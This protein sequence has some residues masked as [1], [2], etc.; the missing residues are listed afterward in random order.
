MVELVEGRMHAIQLQIHATQVEAWDQIRQ[1]VH[2]A[3]AGEGCRQ[4]A[5][6]LAHLALVD[7][8]WGH[9]AQH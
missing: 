5:Q 7:G 1:I 4:T 8:Q 6:Q 9:H 2:S 3:E